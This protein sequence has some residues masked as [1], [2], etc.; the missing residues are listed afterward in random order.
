M[1]Y[2]DSPYRSR[3]R[4][5]ALAEYED[6][7]YQDPAPYRDDGSYWDDSAYQGSPAYQGAHPGYQGQAGYLD[8]QAGYTDQYSGDQGYPDAFDGS[9]TGY[10]DG[11]GYANDPAYQGYRDPHPSEPEGWPGYQNPGGYR[12]AGYRNTGHRDSGYS[13]SGYSDSGY[14][15]TMVASRTEA[16]VPSARP[17]GGGYL[18]DWQQGGL[19]RPGGLGLMTGAIAGFLA[20]A[21]VLG[22]ATLTSALVGRAASPVTALDGIFTERLPSAL[23]SSA[24]HHFGGHDRVVLLLGMYA[25]IAIIAMVIGN[26]AR[27]KTAIG[28]MGIAAFG[29]LVAY[30]VIT[31]PGS[32]AADAIPSA[33]GALAGVGALLYLVRASL[34]YIGEVA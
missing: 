9:G 27:R 8:Q 28:V 13:D 21:V 33:I 11:R 18:D 19:T 10:Q 2:Q 26:I 15:D 16:G 31:R 1:T 32:Q 25:V 14:Q 3:P 30:I 17:G 7:A 29:L 24:V 23:K 12:D 6:S 22:I 34:P 20:A 5:P 4:Y